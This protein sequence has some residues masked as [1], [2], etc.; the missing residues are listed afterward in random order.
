MDSFFVSV[1]RGLDP[2]LEGRAVLVAGSPAG[3]GVVVACSYEARGKGVRS[4]MPSGRAIA[5]CPEAVVLPPRAKVYTQLSACVLRILHRQ[6]DRLE[7]ASVDEAYLDLTPIRGGCCGAVRVGRKIREEVRRE[8]GLVASVGIG[9]T[10]TIA[11]IA[12]RLA[13]PDGI[14]CIPPDRIRGSVHPLPVDAI[15]G[16]GGKTAASLR[17]LGI[18]T[19]GDLA[20]ADDALLRRVFGKNGALLSRLSRA[21][22]DRPVLPFRSLPDP[23][24]MS[25]ERT[26][27]RDTRDEEV[28]E[29]TLLHLTE[30]LARRL[31]RERLAGETFH[32]KLRFPDFRTILRSRTLPERTND[33]RTLRHLATDGVRR[34]ARGRALRL[35]GVGLSGLAR[36][37]GAPSELDLDRG[38][39]SYRRSLP[40]FDAV[41]DRFGETVL[42]KARLL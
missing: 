36:A 37:P 39:R 26:L 29:T 21:E 5:L 10:K 17:A 11:K 9:P 40:V 13:K 24:S 32:L 6:T 19:I 22:G 38:R 30:K 2:R 31:R 7:P 16:V 25:N 20:A 41:R 33:E 18:R 12:S 34:H 1:E 27:P 35:I 4:G 42:K 8:L 3:R 23:K 28:I 15:G 14:E